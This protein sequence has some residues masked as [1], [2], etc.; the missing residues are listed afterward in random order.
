M[1]ITGNEANQEGEVGE[2]RLGKEGE[3]VKGNQGKL[4]EQ[5][6]GSRENEGK[7]LRGNK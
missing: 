1:G 5:G 4:G 2:M 7:E 6:W 3:T